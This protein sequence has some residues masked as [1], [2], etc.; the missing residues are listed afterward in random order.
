VQ[1]ALAASGD[2]WS[3]AVREL[4]VALARDGP[5]PS[6]C[7]REA[8]LL[9]THLGLPSTTQLLGTGGVVAGW[10]GRWAMQLLLAPP[11]VR[12]AAGGGYS[13]RL[14]AHTTHTHTTLSRVLP[15]RGPACGAPFALLPL[16]HAFLTL[17]DQLSG[18]R[19]VV[20][21]GLGSTG[22]GLTVSLSLA[23]VCLV[24]VGVRVN[25]S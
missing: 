10:C 12:G 20:G 3:S 17:F 1:E 16:P 14:E 6:T 19:L 13:L 18:K 9:C 5:T 8:G 25:P 24:R 23:C 22:L 15:L 21:T 4:S 7:M 2:D 11:P